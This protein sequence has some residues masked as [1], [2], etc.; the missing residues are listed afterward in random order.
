MRQHLRE[1]MRNLSLI[2]TNDSAQ[3]E[4]VVI[5]CASVSAPTGASSMYS[6]ITPCSTHTAM[7]R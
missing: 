6:C 7:G 2:G 3:I 4:R 5:A 1:V